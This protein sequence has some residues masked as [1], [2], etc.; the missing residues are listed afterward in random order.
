MNLLRSIL[1]VV[2][3]LWFAAVLLVVWLLAMAC[4]T[5]FE[6]MR[7]TEQAL[8]IFYGSWWF[9]T[10]LALIAVNVTASVL[11][12]YPF[13][14]KL[15]GFVVTHVS[16]L[17]VLAGALMTAQL[18]VDGTVGITEGET[19]DMVI[20]R[21]ASMLLVSD[22]ESPA[23][24]QVDLTD[25]TFS[26][27]E[28]VDQ[29]NVPPATLGNAQVNIERYVPD[30]EWVRQVLEDNDPRLPAAIQVRLSS[31]DSEE[32]DWVFADHP[33]QAGQ[34]DVVFRSLRTEAELAALLSAD[35]DSQTNSVG[36]VK[37]N[38]AGTSYEIPVEDCQEQAAPLGTTGYS[39]RVLRYL[40]HAIVGMSGANRKIQNASQQPV[41]PTIEVEIAGNSQS[42][43][44][45]CFAK[46]P[47]FSHK[48]QVIEGMA[49]TFVAN[50]GA[51]PTVPI[52]ILGGPNGELYAR[53]SWEGMPTVTH[54]LTLGTPVETPWPD[55]TLTVL[56]RLAHGRM[57]W[58]LEPVTPPRENRT[59][60]LLVSVQ[61]PDRREEKWV[62]KHRAEQLTVGTT[63]YEMVYVGKQVPLGF[64]ITLDRFRVNTYPGTSRPRSYES[65]VT[66]VDPATGAEESRVISMNHPAEFGGYTL[67]QSSYDQRGAK[68]TT[69][70]SCSRDPGRPVAF[71]GYIG[72]M[73][74]MV[75][76]LVTR[77][78]DQRRLA[79]AGA[80]GVT[81]RGVSE[82]AA[83]RGGQA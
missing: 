44:R 51:G 41:N 82:T 39:I 57:E 7:G 48:E 50:D 81:P 59:P 73:V 21:D 37:V 49:V 69:F 9:E 28:I 13:S 68:A 67:Y 22:P 24:L 15:T 74:G 10:L 12:R 29:P 64:S 8:G 14:K 26:G 27:F 20:L 2:G 1:R 36:T 70:L 75:M 6:S 4:A 35:R 72:L 61:R 52:E 54:E 32:T 60:A 62:Q 33:T 25:D 19:S 65:H 40:P 17:V 11:L 79:A 53:F 71:A 30:S 18:A 63:D 80:T 55:A 34:Q 56:R 76:V 23:P 78:S 46:M 47:G 45:F 58:S 77:M 66:F 31:P 5:V 16:I 42:E 3:S 83:R 43:T 38:Y